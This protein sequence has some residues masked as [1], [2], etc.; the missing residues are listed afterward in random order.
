MHD[1]AMFCSKC[2]T[3]I[4]VPTQK[5]ET[6]KP[7]A[8]AESVSAAPKPPIP[9]KYIFIPSGIL[10]FAVVVLVIA[11]V[12]ALKPKDDVPVGG[13]SHDDEYIQQST[14]SD[15]HDHSS[16]ISGIFDGSSTPAEEY[17]P[18]EEQRGDILPPD[19]PK[20]EHYT[21]DKTGT[22]FVIPPEGYAQIVYDGKENTVTA[23]FETNTPTEYF[24]YDTY[25]WIYLDG[26]TGNTSKTNIGFSL[27][28]SVGGW[29][30]GKTLDLDDLD[31][32][33]NYL[34][35]RGIYRVYMSYVGSYSEH[36]FSNQ[37]KSYFD[38]ACL[39]VIDLDSS[40]D[41]LKCYFYV[42]IHDSSSS[43]TIEGVANVRRDAN[44]GDSS[45][46]SGSYD[47]GNAGDN[48][49][50]VLPSP[51]VGTR[52]CAVCQ[53]TGICSV[54]DG[55]GKVWGWKQKVTCTNCHGTLKCQACN[56]G[57]Y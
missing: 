1:N 25:L 47:G 31:S 48:T 56:G 44:A 30:A 2:G 22:S 33:M 53:G 32:K 6:A 41:V 35:V 23:E 38:D 46:D 37:N 8:P 34:A 4:A 19:E 7:A 11:L 24:N 49:Q 42:Q 21:S 36:I 12:V 15:D 51:D 40:G 57:Y 45:S 18:T 13:R 39:T 20:E 29:K 27:T 55:S 26:G 52:R 3:K 54:C 16:G 14:H 17:S 9:L 43:H 10:A 28:T 5:V 50:A